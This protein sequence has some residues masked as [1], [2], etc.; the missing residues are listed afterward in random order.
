[1]SIRRQFVSSG[2]DFARVE[3]ACSEVR[4]GCSKV[5]VC[6]SLS[7]FVVVARTGIEP[8]RW[9]THHRILSPVRLPISPPG[10]VCLVASFNSLNLGV[11][12]RPNRQDNSQIGPFALRRSASGG[13]CSGCRRRCG[14]EQGLVATLFSLRSRTRPLAASVRNRTDFTRFSDKTCHSRENTYK[15]IGSWYPSPGRTR[16][17][18]RLVRTAPICV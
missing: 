1:M 7:V 16:Q 14:S 15:L 11:A 12:C 5:R 13:Y 17:V 2:L 4:E 10:R 3:R 9:I 8:V 6:P 18:R